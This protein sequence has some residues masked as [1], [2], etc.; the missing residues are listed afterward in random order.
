MSALVFTLQN[1]AGKVIQVGK[2]STSLDDAKTQLTTFLT[3]EYKALAP[4]LNSPS[5]SPSAGTSALDEI[6][7]I[8]A[9]P[10]GQHYV[11]KENDLFWSLK[12]KSSE[13]LIFP[14]AKTAV[15]ATYTFHVLDLSGKEGDNLSML[16]ESDLAD[17]IRAAAK[18]QR[19]VKEAEKKLAAES[20]ENLQTFLNFY[21]T[22]H[23]QIA[24]D[25]QAYWQ[26]RTIAKMTSQDVDTLHTKALEI[27]AAVD[28]CRPDILNLLGIILRT[29]KKDTDGAIHY[30]KLAA[31][32]G[33][34]IAM[35]NLLSIYVYSGICKSKDEIDSLRTKLM[36]AGYSDQ[37]K[38]YNLL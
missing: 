16:G 19:E 13:G 9:Y 11:V 24:W 30:Y 4:A 34:H 33:F 31:A 25:D 28:S 10:D 35:A 29:G 32:T 12:V 14:S 3:N 20:A 6:A 22:E 17:A 23:K 8:S 38:K 1:G 21:A 15:V 26:G 5:T 36:D 2:A 37:L 27:N 18:N 7:A